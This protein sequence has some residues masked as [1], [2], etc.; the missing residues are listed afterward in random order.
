MFAQVLA[1]Q[2]F[3]PPGAVTAHTR[4]LL[5][6]AAGSHARL[7]ESAGAAHHQQLDRLREALGGYLRGPAPATEKRFVLDDPQLV[8]ALHALASTSDD[9]A[10][11]D[12]AVAP[13]DCHPTATRRASLGRGRLGNVVAAVQLRRC[14]RWCGRIELATDEYGRVHLP[15]CDWALVL[16]DQHGARR[17][18]LAHQTI[19]LD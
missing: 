17:D 14:R 7:L 19:L 16:V 1:R 15:C 8:E 4:H 11:W 13:D 2:L 3:A 5:A 12:A 9:L 6:Q 18:L 10:G